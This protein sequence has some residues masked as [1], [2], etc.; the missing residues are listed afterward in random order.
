MTSSYP[1][2]PLQ[3]EAPITEKRPG[4][5]PRSKK[6]DDP[7]AHGQSLKLQLQQT[8]KQ[9]ELD[10]GGFDDRKLFRFQIEK[11][12]FNPEDLKKISKEIEFVS[13]EA[14]EILV[15]FVSQSALQAF[16]ARLS[17]IAD[18][19]TITNKQIYYALQGMSGW[20]AEDRT[21]WSLKQE[22]LPTTETFYLDLEL[23]PIEDNAKE[24]Q[25]LWSQ[26][27]TWL[28]ENGIETPDSVKQPGLTIYRIRCNHKQAE[29]L[30][31]HRDIRIVDLPPRFGMEIKHL[32]LDIQNFPITPAPLPSAPGI[33]VLDSGLATGH[34]LLGSAVGDAQSFLP[35]HLAAD[36]SGHGTHVAGI[37]LYGD[38]AKSIEAGSFTPELRLFS[39]RILDKENENN[40]L[41][42]N[43][44]DTAVRYFV[45]E[46]NC[47]IF[48]LSFGDS[49]KPFR[50]GHLRGLA[51]ILD[52]LSRELG[53]LFVVSAGNVL[54]SKLDG[55]AWKQDYP[56]YLIYEDWSIIDP[57][58]ALNVLTVGSVARW[59]ASL[60][61][62]RY[63]HDPAELPIAKTEQPSPFTRHG[64]TVGGAIKPEL[65]AFGGNWALNSRNGVNN[66][67]EDGLGELS[68]NL[69]FA[70]GRL[71]GVKCGTS[72]AAPYV[73]H[74]AG[75]ILS[76]H[77]EASANL[78]RALLVT[79]ANIPKSS[80]E[81]FDDDSIRKVLGYGHVDARGLLKSLE[82]EVTL[83]AEA[84][85]E[86]KRHH[87]YEVLVPED[88]VSTGKR[89][90]EL[91]VSLAHSPLI[92]STRVSYKATRLYYQLIAA[93]DLDYV[94]KMFNKA[95]KDEDYKNIAELGKASVG[96][97][98]RSKGTVQSGLW[99]FKQSNCNSKLKTQ[100]LFVVVTRNDHA[101]GELVANIQ[102]PYSLVVCFRDREN[103]QAKL[104]SQIQ[105]RLQ[106]RQ[107]AR[108]RG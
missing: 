62:Q 88:F 108:A 54:Q 29:Q 16:E 49:R 40:G 56:E 31:L 94:V 104:Y 77:P 21:G 39:G 80:L 76:E 57:A 58:T 48:N 70:Q 41:I 27:E 99:E 72:F 105:N 95:T 97:T 36:E 23:W 81:I 10:I 75:K 89:H 82:N 3:R 59:E 32:G 93:P 55:L 91:A 106:Q 103:Q 60:N 52:S 33:V 47:R 71:L 9:T 38:L 46:Y 74:L 84:K 102:E 45:K 86:N 18:G 13:Q 92:R 101:W 5:P 1:H 90:R 51:F 44:I 19:E 98:L 11:G 107:R 100:K 12:F 34:P 85:I 61:A 15:A 17:S 73:S 14:D 26:F 28:K 7:M 67:L 83:I 43:H 24:R 25:Q 22:G 37:A 87:F 8:I 30:L 96:L 79:H 63:S 78:L 66:I 68:T 65:V 6:L 50:G 42:E 35:G 4:P 20:T 69:D 64:P 53:V 2:L